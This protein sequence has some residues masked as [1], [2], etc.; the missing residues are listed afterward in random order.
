[1]KYA[2][3]IYDMENGIF[4]PRREFFQEHEKAEEWMHSNG[5]REVTLAWKPDNEENPSKIFMS[6]VICPVF[7]TGTSKFIQYEKKEE[8]LSP[9]CE[10]YFSHFV[11][12]D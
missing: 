3:L 11:A 6:L 12:E 4:V 2:H 9:L 7:E 8:I 10:T 5:S 1:M